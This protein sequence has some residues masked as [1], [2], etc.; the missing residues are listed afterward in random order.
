MKS[1]YEYTGET[2]I[3]LLS[4]KFQAM[5]KDDKFKGFVSCDYVE[6]T[7]CW[8]KYNR[9]KPKYIPDPK[10]LRKANLIQQK[11]FNNNVKKLKKLGY[12][13]FG[14]IFNVGGEPLG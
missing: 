3:K 5:F 12:K 10:S 6:Y 7:L 1:I 13:P 4:R 2:M 9:V 11:Q 8:H 14:K